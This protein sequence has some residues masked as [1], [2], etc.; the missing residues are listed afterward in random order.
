MN[1]PDDRQDL[2]SSDRFRVT[3][4]I[5]RPDGIKPEIPQLDQPR[6]QVKWHPGWR[7][8]QLVG[9]VIAFSVLEALQVAVNT[10]SDATLSKY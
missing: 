5:D 10:W 7:T 6:G 9:R 2:C 1:C 3:C 8:H 4:W